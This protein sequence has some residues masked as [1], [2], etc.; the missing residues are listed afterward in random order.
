MLRYKYP[1]EY[2]LNPTEIDKGLQWLTLKL[3]NKGRV[4][5]KRLDVELHSI[6]T[7]PLTLFF[8]LMEQDTTSESLSQMNR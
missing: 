5:L 2:E 1:I 4:P 6:D 8:S 7:F 3:K